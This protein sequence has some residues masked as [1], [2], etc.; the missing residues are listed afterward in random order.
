MA[1]TTDSPK[2]SAKAIGVAGEQFFIARALEEGL[3]LSLPIGDNLPYDVLVDSGKHIHRVQVKTC[4]YPKKTKYSFLLK[5]GI[6]GV[7]YDCSDI[8]F[9]VLVALPVRVLYISPSQKLGDCIKVA[10]W[11]TAEDTQGR[12]EVYRERWD[13]LLGA[14]LGAR[15]RQPAL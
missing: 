3:N 14:P 15:T 9:F 1:E 7:R 6:D 10:A 8:D 11:P 4:A 5:R 12:L 13:L 2:L